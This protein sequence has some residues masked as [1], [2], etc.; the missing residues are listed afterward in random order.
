AGVFVPSEDDFT[1]KNIH[2]G[3]LLG[4]VNDTEVRSPLSGELQGYLAVD[5]ERVTSSQ[6]IAWLRTTK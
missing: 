6:P 5:G 4:H 2:T 3:F 1:G